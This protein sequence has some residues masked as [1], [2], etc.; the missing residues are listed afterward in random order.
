MTVKKLMSFLS[1]YN[2]EK[3]VLIK[4]DNGTVF[5]KYYYPTVVYT[6]NKG[7]EKELQILI[8]AE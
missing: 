6:Q 3:E 1:M 7:E 8:G 4:I 5:P 2:P